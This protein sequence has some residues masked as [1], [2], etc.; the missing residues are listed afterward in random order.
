MREKDLEESEAVLLSGQ[1][2]LKVWFWTLVTKNQVVQ[3]LVN[4][5]TKV[6][7]GGSE[8]QEKTLATWTLPIHTGTPTTMEPQQGLQPH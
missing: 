8:K 7:I 4:K 6:Q 2:R 1:D 5:R 3:I